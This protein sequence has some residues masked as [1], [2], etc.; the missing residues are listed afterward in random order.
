MTFSDLPAIQS[1]KFMCVG[2]KSGASKIRL[3][4][5]ASRA[6]FDTRSSV[7]TITIHKLHV[8]FFFPRIERA[9]ETVV[10][11]EVKKRVMAKAK[12]PRFIL[13][14]LLFRFLSL[15]KLLIRS[16]LVFFF[17]PSLQPYFRYLLLL[18]RQANHS[19][20]FFETAVCAFTPCT[21]SGRVNVHEREMESIK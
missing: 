19:N 21:W 12:L 18:P 16:T 20:F 6:V 4:F 14:F 1:R 9:P 5:I 7:I 13:V 11:D 10:V 2:P 8:S 3:H 17:P 15:S